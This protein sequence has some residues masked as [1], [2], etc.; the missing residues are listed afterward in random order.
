MTT[1]KKVN[2]NKTSVKTN[3]AKEIKTDENV[4]QSAKEAL[5]QGVNNNRGDTESNIYT[6]AHL[7]NDSEY[8]SKEERNHQK[9]MR[10][11]R[12]K[13][14]TKLE[15]HFAKFLLIKKNAEVKNIP[16]DV[17]LQI[18]DSENIM[19]E[20]LTFYKKFYKLN[21]FSPSSVAN[22]QR[23]EKVASEMKTISDYYLAIEKTKK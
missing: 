10:A 1:S 19:A 8:L 4:L 11:Y 13:L 20:F 17:V 3:V 14:R 2:A 7:V 6:F 18:I 16:M 5:L 9:T 15:N 23:I 12:N 22:N 21:D